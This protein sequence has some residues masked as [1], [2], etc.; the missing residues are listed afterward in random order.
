MKHGTRIEVDNAIRDPTRCFSRPRRRPHSGRRFR[1]HRPVV[2]ATQGLVHLEGLR[3][4][5]A[6]VALHQLTSQ[7]G[8]VCRFA[9]EDAVHDLKAVNPREKRT[10]DTR[11]PAE[12]LAAIEEKGQTVE[13][14]LARLT[15][16]IASNAVAKSKS[17]GAGKWPCIRI[18]RPPGASRLA[19]AV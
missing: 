12:L 8:P 3:H 4:T 13:T 15:E 14:E 9:T 17:A 6:F 11:T 10:T 19:V 18:R 2:V 7:A 5:K 16:L 1:V